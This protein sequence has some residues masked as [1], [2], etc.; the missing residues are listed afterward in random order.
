MILYKTRITNVWIRLRGCAGW[1]APVLFANPRRQVFSHRVPNDTLFINCTQF[2]QIHSSAK[3]QIRL[4][5][6]A[7]DNICKLVIKHSGLVLVTDTAFIQ[8]KSKAGNQDSKGAAC[9]LHM[10]QR[11]LFF[12]LIAPKW[13]R[14]HTECLVL[15]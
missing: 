14:T 9:M 8:A 4:W 5:L 12:S 7:L 2:E 10:I 11:Q 3:I 13:V 6:L 1:P 15:A